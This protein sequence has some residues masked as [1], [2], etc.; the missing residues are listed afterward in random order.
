MDNQNQYANVKDPS[1][2][3]GLISGEQS[4]KKRRILWDSWNR[5]KDHWVRGAGG[6]CWPARAYQGFKGYHLEAHDL[7]SIHGYNRSGEMDRIIRE[8]TGEPYLIGIELEIEGVQDRGIVG[9]ALRKYLKDR[10][11][12]VRDG[13]IASNGVEIVTSPLAPREMGRIPWYNLLRELSREGCTSHD[14]G[15]CGLHVSISRNYLK[16]HTWRSIRSM[17][18]RDRALFESLSRRNIGKGGKNGDPFYFCSFSP[19]ESKYQALN[20]SKGAVAE[21]R[22]FRGTLSPASFIASI[23]IVRSIVEYARDRE[24]R[25][26]DRAP[27]L[28]AVGWIEW[29]GNA[30][31]YGVARDYIK[32]HVERFRAI[33]RAPRGAGRSQRVARFIADQIRGCGGATVTDQGGV[34]INSANSVIGGL[35]GLIQGEPVEYTIPIFW[36]RCFNLPQYVRDAVARG[37]APREIVFRSNY[38]GIE[39]ADPIGSRGIVFSYYRGGWGSRS[40]LY[41]SLKQ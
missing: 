18:S 32:D 9:D 26:G 14:S 37:H 5:F 6:V 19:R 13:S 29:V 21:F 3:R 33:P 24:N 10:H 1:V 34:V 20:L 8:R 28:T 39:G 12:C 27:R 4:A 36:D 17:L 35:C 22:F 15:A 30:W 16:D 23:E 11:I 25:S 40:A 38:K 41:A 31:G 2:S 7:I